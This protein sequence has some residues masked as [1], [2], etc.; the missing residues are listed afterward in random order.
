MMHAVMFA[1][2]LLLTATAKEDV[3]LTRFRSFAKEHYTDPVIE[4]ASGYQL[5]FL[6]GVRFF[7]VFERRNQAEDP[8]I[9]HVWAVTNRGIHRSHELPAVLT[10]IGFVPGNAAEAVAA[11]ELLL[12]CTHGRLDVRQS[13]ALAPDQGVYRVLF[14]LT[15]HDADPRQPAIPGSGQPRDMLVTL[16]KGIC[17]TQRLDVPAYGAEVLLRKG[18]TI[19]FPEGPVVTLDGHGHKRTKMGGPPSPL[20]VNLTYKHGNTIEQASAN[21]FPQEAPSGR[22]WEWNGF[23]F[24]MTAHAY[25]AWMIVVVVDAP[26]RP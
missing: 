10:E 15:V 21:L 17:K 23:A 7:S 8:L 5:P 6:K 25:D 26:Q 16:G 20:I 9:P 24:T 19:T 14:E 4:D 3:L 18:Q 12:R 22:A 1:L 2:P 11:G 13:T